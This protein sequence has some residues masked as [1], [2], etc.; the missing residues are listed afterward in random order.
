MRIAVLT[1]K[2]PAVT[3]TFIATEV[4]K[5]AE[6]GHTVD[7][8]AWGGDL[9]SGGQNRPGVAY[10]SLSVHYLR[11][12]RRRAAQV[13]VAGIAAGRSFMRRG[14]PLSPILPIVP[15]IKRSEWGTFVRALH[16]WRELA[17]A[18]DY[19]IIHCHFGPIGTIGAMLKLFGVAGRLVVTFHGFDVS[20][21]PRQ[22]GRARYARLFEVGD[23]FLT[24]S[25]YFK[26][27][28]IALGAPSDRVRVHRL[29]IDLRRFPFAHR[30][31]STAGRIR[32][33]TV[34]R[35]VEKKGIDYAIRAVA[36]VL[37]KHPEWPVR[38]TI[39]G[40]GPLR[41]ELRRLIQASG[42]ERHV[43]MLGFQSHEEVARLMQEADLFVLPSVTASDGDQEGIPV[44]LM[45]AMAT[46]LP[47]I[48][49]LHSGIPELVHHMEN[50]VLVPERDVEA[51]AEAIEWVIQRQDGGDG[52]A[53]NAR[54]TI[55]ELHDADRQVEHL[56]EIYRE[57]LSHE[58]VVNIGT[59]S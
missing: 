50:G 22:E 31:G 55:E 58:R 30:R 26:E 56:E 21:V 18:G 9:A 10:P 28:I 39:V 24:V 11:F 29:G 32:L 54:R 6:R 38:Y 42:I 43:Q 12:P 44:S 4:L 1:G 2:F 47:V 57:V 20:R 48:T 46:G 59:L 49:T 19:D 5:L 15:T 3:E 53:A 35:L 16:T 40:D 14:S 13:I 7:V 8:Y 36:H 27:R 23:A 41:G 34:A 37:R 17:V 45:E 33:L 25:R 51:L 52:L